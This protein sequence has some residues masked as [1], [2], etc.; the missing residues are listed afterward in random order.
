M[1]TNHDDLRS[2]V[3]GHFSKG[4][5]PADEASLRAHLPACAACRQAYGDYQVA[6]RLDPRA[7]P[8][9]ERLAAALGLA[10]EV[11]TPVRR[12]L[13]WALGA[14]TVVGAVALLLVA[15]KTS[16]GTGMVARGKGVDPLASL[17]VAIFRVKG[18]RES[19]RVTDVVSPDDQ[20]A[21]AY[22][23]ELGKAFLMIFAM[24]GAGHTLWYYPAWTDPADNPTAVPITTQVGLKELPEAVRHALQG[25]SLTVYALFMDQALDVRAVEARAARGEFAAEPG[26]GELLRKFVFEVSP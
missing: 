8:P 11:N 3:D 26:A 14:A 4:L 5:S 19:A 21:F 18:E 20:L 10:R 16:P 24:D 2:L 22:R 12:G 17:D 25:S 6:E 13:R 1:S 9:R 7:R 15:T 23:N